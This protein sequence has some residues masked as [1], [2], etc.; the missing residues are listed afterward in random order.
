M[1]VNFLFGRDSGKNN[2]QPTKFDN[3][4]LSTV[5]ANLDTWIIVLIYVYP[6]ELQGR[7]T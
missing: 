2:D 1:S 7:P 4:T 3:F 6:V 5:G